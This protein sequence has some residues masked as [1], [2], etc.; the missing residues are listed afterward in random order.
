MPRKVIY[1]CCI[2]H[3]RVPKQKNIKLLKQ[4]YGAGNYN[5]FSQTGKFN[6]CPHCYGKIEAWIEKHNQVTT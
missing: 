2:C 6:F 5:Q 4:E 3:R 1:Y